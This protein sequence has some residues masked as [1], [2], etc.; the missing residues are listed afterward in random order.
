MKW[1]KWLY[2][3]SAIAANIAIGIFVWSNITEAEQ[4]TPVLPEPVP[5]VVKPV[6]VV[7]KEQTPIAVNV[8][9]DAKELECLANNIYF[10][11]LSEPVAGQIAVA[12]VTMN[13][14]AS[15]YFPNTVC[16]V[17]WANSQFSWTHD[18][19]SDTPV[20]GK[21]YNDIYKLAKDVYT[22]KIGDITEGSTFYHADYVN[23]GWAKRMDR[24]VVKIGAHIFYW[25]EGI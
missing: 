21:Q 5:V 18:G 1:Y 24:K 15:E 4:I 12:N 8:V 17:V 23:P 2:Y 14:V 16:E 3:S 7:V 19:K 25:H 22:G 20:A 13:R 11:S 10:E 9:L 6:P